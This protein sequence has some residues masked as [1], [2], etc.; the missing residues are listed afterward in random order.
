VFTGA[1]V[2]DISKAILILLAKALI[3]FSL[4]SGVPA[5][6]FYPREGNNLVTQWRQHF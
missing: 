6:G 4:F 1:D 2:K 3:C 5:V